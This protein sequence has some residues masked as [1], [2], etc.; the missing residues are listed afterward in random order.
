MQILPSASASLSWEV[1]GLVV[2]EFLMPVLAEDNMFEAGV[3]SSINTPDIADEIFSTELF[4]EAVN[5]TDD[6]TGLT[7][8]YGNMEPQQQ[9]L[10]MDIMETDFTEDIWGATSFNDVAS[11]EDFGPCAPATLVEGAETVI[12]EPLEITPDTALDIDH[13][14]LLKWIIDDQEID[15]LQTADITNDAADVMTTTTT[16]AERVSVIVPVSD[17]KA[18]PVEA[19][20]EPSMEPAFEISIKMENLTEDEKY[21]KMREQNN[22]ASRKCRMKRKRKLQEAEDELQQLMERNIL[23]KAK[24]ETMERQV[25]KFKTIVLADISVKN[26]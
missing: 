6:Q 22:E 13:V 19:S 23:L 26:L 12:E 9:Q 14:D 4:K 25:K 18:D 21:R 2:P 20:L 7:T 10:D 3:E 11:T 5:A 24:L 16:A 1:D 17:I 8:G 15:D